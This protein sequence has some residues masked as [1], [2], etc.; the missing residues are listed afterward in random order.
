MYYAITRSKPLP[1]IDILASE[2]MLRPCHSF[3]K[4]VSADFDEA[5]LKAMSEEKEARFSSVGEFKKVLEEILENVHG[6]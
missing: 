5:I 4:N 1:A 3:N 6:L 2:E